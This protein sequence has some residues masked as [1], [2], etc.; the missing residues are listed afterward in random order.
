MNKN[1]GKQCLSDVGDLVDFRPLEIGDAVVAGD[2]ADG[3]VDLGVREQLRLLAV[4]DGADGEHVR[5][6]KGLEL[7]E[8]FEH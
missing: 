1:R 6:L 3:D 7:R 2:V 8:S 4:V 5:S